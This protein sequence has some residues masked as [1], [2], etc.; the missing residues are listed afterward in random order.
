VRTGG[1]QL[2]GGGD[3]L[4]IKQF[5]ELMA[6]TVTCHHDGQIVNFFATPLFCDREDLAYLQGSRAI[7]SLGLGF[8]GIRQLERQFKDALS[9]RGL[10]DLDRDVHVARFRV[11]Y[12]SMMICLTH[13]AH[14]KLARKKVN[15]SKSIVDNLTKQTGGQATL[16]P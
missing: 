15:K 5:A 7:E 3:E 9:V 11:F 6:N 1:W 13:G 2:F 4:T 10:S 16:Y 8:L 12:W 14:R